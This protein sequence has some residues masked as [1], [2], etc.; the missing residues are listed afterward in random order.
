MVVVSILYVIYI[1]FYFNPFVEILFSFLYIID[2]NLSFH[3][4][5]TFLVVIYTEHSFNS[6][7]RILNSLILCVLNIEWCKLK[8]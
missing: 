1:E 8:S 4:T 3:A 2:L 7:F 6:K 5:L